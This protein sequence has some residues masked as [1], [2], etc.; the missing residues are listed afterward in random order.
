[1][2]GPLLESK[3]RAPG[4]RP[5]TVARPRLLDVLDGTLE[6][7]LTVVS[8]PAG[9]GK[10]TLLAEWLAAVPASTA[11]VAWV[12]LD[13]RDDDPTRFWTYVVTAVRA[14]TGVGGSAL[15]LLTSAP[16]SIESTLVAVLND[17]GASSRDVVLV[18][19]DVHLVTSPEVHEGIAFLLEHRP[20]QLHLVLAT[21]V[22]PP[23]PLARW[24]ARG[25][26]VEVRAADLRFTEQESAT[27]LNGPMGL[28]LSGHDVATLDRRAEGWIAALQLAALSMRGRDDVG[29]FIAGF[30]GDDR[31]VVD[32]LAEEVLARLPDATRDFLLETSVLE[33]LTGPLCDAV[34]GR[35]DGRGTLVA[36]ERANLFLVPLDDR[37]QWYRYH[38]LFADVLRAHLT[39]ERAQT[40]PE[41]HRRASA[42]LADTGDVPA[43]V[44]HA[45]AGGHVDRA[46]DLMERAMPTMRRERREAEL[47]RWARSMPDEVV[48]VRPVLGMAFA[49]A[50]AQASQFDTVEQ[51]LADVE[52]AVGPAGGAWPAQPPPGLVVVDE[53]GYRSVPAG[54][55]LYRA[56]LALRRADLGATSAHAQQALSLTPAADD[57]T[58]AAAGALGGLA[59]WARGDLARAEAAYVESLA[60]LH[61]AGFVADVLGC[62]IALGDIRRTLG[63]LGDAERLHR[64]ALALTDPVAPVRGTADMHV[65]LAG[66]L[67]ER[68]DLTGA[69]EHLDASRRLGEHRGLPQNPYRSRVVQARLLEARGD[70]DG[71]L[72]LLDEAER[73]HDT[74]YSPDVAPVPAVRA[75][76][77]L[78]RGELRD[79][80][81]WARDRRLTADDET[82]YLREYEHLTLARVLLARRDD[83]G[84]GAAA[85]LLARLEAAAEQGARSGSLIEVLVLRALVA[86]ARRD[87]PSALDALRRAVTLA[88][89]EGFVRVVA[90]EGPPIAALLRALPRHDPAHA[91]GRRL[92]AAVVGAPAPRTL[93]D[94]LSDRE[95]DVLR[96]LGSDLGGPEIARELSVSLNTVRTHT[97]S[98][99][100]KL[101]VTSRRAAVHR[102]HDLGV[103]PRVR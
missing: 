101:G 8:A 60:G 80:E 72:A 30:A 82:T 22:D 78:R 3:Y 20:P 93:V 36:L 46:A 9:F 63:R 67:L 23:L 49:G 58:R 10:S 74:D 29:A 40:I 62:C 88:E 15:G 2:A 77:R 95:L 56:A 90:D 96:L 1:M 92:L 28:A 6:A 13:E 34:T 37:R 66:V 79:A 14:A 52:R 47:V 35:D 42:W 54:L 68:D 19:D 45:L 94:P 31:H 84:P 17:V 76:L 71:A 75:R 73:V 85:G 25:E 55:E 7:A 102:A 50:L 12:S 81:A 61:R 53:E 69:A 70:L 57:L 65:A 27:Y 86:Q 32:Y 91:H 64:W 59:S 98:I 38:H 16:S 97:K 100:A 18:L 87:V 89:P 51:R 4:R 26:L 33:R 48:R 11:A 103:L 83:A 24:R 21:R 5:G 39:D 43:A 99:Y 44:D 41:L